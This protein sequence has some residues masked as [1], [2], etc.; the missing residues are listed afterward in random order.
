MTKARVRVCLGLLLL[1]FYGVTASAQMLYR[2]GQ[3]LQPVYEGFEKNPDGSY[4]MWFGYLNRNYEETPSITIGEANLFQVADGV[5]ASGPVDVSLLATDPGPRDRG[6]PTYFYP[7][8]QQFVFSVQVPADFIGKELVWTLTHNGESHTAVGTLEK[9]NVWSVDEGVWS[10]NRGRGIGGRTEVEYSNSPPQIRVVGVEGQVSTTVGQP[11]A[12]RTFVSD[13]G[14]PGAYQGRRRADPAPLPNN[15]P[16]IGGRTGENSPKTQE[17]VN[18]LAA[19]ATGLAVTWILYRGPGEVFFDTNAMPAAPGGEEVLSSA[20]FSRPGTY[21][22]R[23][24]A[25][26]GNY[27][28]YTDATV[29]VR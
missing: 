18:Y 8:R 2:F 5:N 1:L 12:L 22:L 9:Q 3:S 26:D 27:T 19:D 16:E 21:V 7:R 13:D 17:V 14:L 28:R 23:A 6:Q 24:Y 25:D 15:L 29:V 20:T 11:V 10:A 4:T